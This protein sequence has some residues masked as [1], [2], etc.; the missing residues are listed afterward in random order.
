[1]PGYERTI[2]GPFW[3]D[4]SHLGWHQLIA[5]MPNNQT[6]K[7]SCFNKNIYGGKIPKFWSDSLD[8]IKLG[9]RQIKWVTF[10]LKITHTGLQTKITLL[11]HVSNQDQSNCHF[12]TKKSLK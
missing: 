4:L 9:V 7:L 2:L 8:L 1:M 6:M 10:M 3:Q 12:F 11:P 5:I